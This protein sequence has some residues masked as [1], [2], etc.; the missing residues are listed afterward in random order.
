MK[1]N[2]IP[3]HL[4]YDKVKNDE[5]ELEKLKKDFLAI[6]DVR[7]KLRIREIIDMMEE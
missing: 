1:M 6:S 4:T 7:C 5:S 3:N 2:S